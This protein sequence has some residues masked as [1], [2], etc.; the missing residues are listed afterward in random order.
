MNVNLLTILVIGIL[1]LLLI[2]LKIFSFGASVGL[3]E[4]L[5]KKYPAKYHEV[6]MDD[7]NAIF[8]IFFPTGNPINFPLFVLSSENFDDDQVVS[9]KRKLR[10]FY[11][12]GFIV[13][14]SLIITIA[15]S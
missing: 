12:I 1:I 5:K 14:I 8:A 4:Y 15:L 9:L 7:S 13:F 3:L 11:L 6:A 2:I 10:I